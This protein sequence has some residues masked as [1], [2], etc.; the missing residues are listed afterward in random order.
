MG[1]CWKLLAATVLLVVPVASQAASCVTQSGLSAQD[2]GALIATG[3]R[4]AEA[5]LRQDDATLQAA[6][7]PAG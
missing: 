7:L 5:V 6:L 2:R 4:L 1:L 3:G